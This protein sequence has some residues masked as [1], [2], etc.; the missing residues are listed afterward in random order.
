VPDHRLAILGGRV[1]DPAQ[2]IDRPAAVL[3]S[4]GVVQ[5]ITRA[6]LARA[7]EGYDVLDA[8]GCTIAPGFIDLHCHL[9]EPGQEHK[10][11]IASGSAAA[12]RGGFTTVCAMPNTDP[13]MDSASIISD[14]L[15]RAAR[16]AAVRVLPIGAIT[17]GR[18]GQQLAPM[19]ELAA[20]GAVAFSDD[21]DPVTDPNLMRQAL[22]YAKSLGRPVINHAEDRSLS[23][24]GQM[25]EG[26]VAARLGLAGI[27]VE[28]EAAMV[29]RDL[30]LAGL[31]GGRLHVPHLSTRQ[32]VEAVRA[33]KAR[34]AAVTAEATPHHLTLTEEWVYGLQGRVPDSLTHAAYDT[35]TKVSPPLRSREDTEAVAAAL[36]DGTVD[37]IATDH[38]PH[39]ATDK[40]CTYFEAAKGINCLETAFGQVMALAHERRV[41]LSRLI[42]GLTAAPA[43]VLGMELGSLK[44]GWPGDVTLF[45]PDEEWIVDPARFASKSRNTPLAGITLKGRVT[46]TVVA[47]KVVW[48]TRVPSPSGRG[49]G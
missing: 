27:P 38:A 25:H 8:Q 48:D 4:G 49:S 45:R 22:M 13:A 47:G 11:T 36:A 39:A 21:G 16:V 43:R 10:E 15:A 40:A 33:A 23:R 24:D 28:A 6:A 31:T 17:V 41:P 29:A 12:A 42:E 32:A 20:A 46:A 37:A 18:H 19:A 35:S 30:M 44:T 14:V 9:R 7:P 2:A 34:G 1:I 5:E 26:P 3:I